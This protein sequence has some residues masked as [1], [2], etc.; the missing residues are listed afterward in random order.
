MKLLIKFPTRERPIKFFKALN[1]YYNLLDDVD[2][3]EFCITIDNDDK[4]MNNDK[5]LD[6]LDKYKNLYYYIGNSK[7][8][9]EAVNADLKDFKDYDILLLA[10]DDM[11]PQ[12]KG[13]DTIIRNEMKKYFP[14]TDGVLWFFDGNNKNT[15]TLAILGKKYYDRFNY[16]Y[17]PDYKTILCDDELTI[18]ANKLGK[19]K[20]FYNVIIK[21]EHPDIPIYRNNIDNLYQKNN[22][23][24]N[25]DRII[26]KKRK[27]I[28]FNLNI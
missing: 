7:T 5:I 8:K 12:V 17:H 9:I 3:T 16:I 23:F 20:R 25:H 19:Q 4:T 10:S 14:D 6:K 2:N 1:L 21:H 11:I 27:Q 18:V 15:N 26:F 22:R 24:M 28:N 13:Y